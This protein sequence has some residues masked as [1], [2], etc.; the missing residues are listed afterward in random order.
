MD[1]TEMQ[2]MMEEMMQDPM[3]QQVFRITFILTMAVMLLIGL[4]VY[5]L[6]A[7]GVHRISSRVGLSHSWMAYV[8]IL[9]WA[10][11]GRLAEC[12]LPSDRP[13][14]K[15]F[16]YSVHL[17]I[18][19]TLSFVLETISSVFV[20][21]YDFLNPD[22][23]PPEAWLGWIN[24]VSMA[25]SVINMI[26][27][28]LLLLALYRVF[29]LVSCQSPMLMTILCALIS[30]CMPILLFAYRKNKIALQPLTPQDEDHHADDDNGFY[31]DN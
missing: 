16:A 9:R 19:M 11:L 28:V 12:R 4:V 21:Y 30:Y 13:R 20:I 27:T 5:I 7:V 31:Y 22:L 8:P 14:R 29:S 25:Y 15:V 6:G 1:Y 23:T 18:L 10:V 24:G 26:V 17:P 3:Y 2:K